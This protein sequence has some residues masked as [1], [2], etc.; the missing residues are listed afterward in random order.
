MPCTL[1][2]WARIG[3]NSRARGEQ[4]GQVE[5]EIHLELGEDP[6]EQPRVEDGADELALHERPQLG[7]ERREVERDDRP[8]AGS[9]KLRDQAVADL[10]VR[11]GD[12]DDGFAHGGSFTAG[13][14]GVRGWAVG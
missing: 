4:R 2:S 7:I 6:L 10:A 14:A 3:V 9:R 5:D 1:T 8:A 12:E 11:A 13:Q